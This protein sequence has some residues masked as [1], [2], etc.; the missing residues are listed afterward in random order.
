MKKDTSLVISVI[1]IG[2]ASFAI[3]MA[4]AGEGNVRH[5]EIYLPEQ[6]QQ[7]IAFHD[8]GTV[9]IVGIVGIGDS[10]N[11]TLVTRS[12]DFAYVLT[13]RNDGESPHMFYIDGLEVQTQLLQPG[14]EETITVFPG[15]PGTYSYYDKADG[16]VRL[17]ELKVVQVVPR[18]AL[19]ET[20]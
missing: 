11:P 16:L 3:L 18:D 10:K 4:F 19:E 7:T 2:I 6:I 17:G 15:K 5:V 8:D 9:E 12:G 14:E 1:A 20:D 13:I